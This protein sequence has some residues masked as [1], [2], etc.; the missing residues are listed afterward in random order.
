MLNNRPISPQRQICKRLSTK[1]KHLL[2]KKKRKNIIKNIK[3]SN[4]AVEKSSDIKH[5]SEEV[6]SNN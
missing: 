6:H 2:I 5:L 3:E 4:N 1:M